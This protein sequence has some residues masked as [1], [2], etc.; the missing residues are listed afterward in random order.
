MMPKIC[1]TCVR[2][3]YTC[4]EL[5]I[6][7]E[8]TYST[9]MKQLCI[10]IAHIHKTLIKSQGVYWLYNK[11]KYALRRAVTFEDDTLEIPA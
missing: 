1:L 8:V 4:C 5:H 10:N 11:A 3:N 7:E 9:K 6:T 2:M